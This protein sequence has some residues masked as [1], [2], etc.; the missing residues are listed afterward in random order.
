MVEFKDRLTRFGFDYLKRYFE[1]HGT[2][3]EV[4]EETEKGY[5]E[6]LIED[7]DSIV[8]GF[9]TRIY[10]KRSKKYRKIKKAIEEVIKVIKTIEKTIKFKLIP[11]AESDRNKLLTLLNDYAAMIREA[12]IMIMKNDDRSRK[13]AHGLC[14]RSLRNKYPYLHNKFA[15]EAYKRALAMYR[16]YRELLNKWRKLPE[17]KKKVSPPSP[18]KIKDNNVTELHIDTYKLERMYRFLI[19]VVSKGNGE[20]LRFLIMEYDYARRELMKTKLGN[21][22]ILVDGDVIFLLLTIRGNVEVREHRNKLIVDIKEDSI[23]CLLVNYDKW[24]A[25]LFSIRHDIRKIRTNYR[26]IR[27]SVQEKVRNPRIRNKLL[28]KYGFRE[29]KRIEDR[30]KKITTLLAEIA[31][32]YNADLVRENLRDLKLN[33]RKRSKQLNYRLPTFPYRR[34]ILYIDYKFYERGLSVIEDD[35]KKLLLLAQYVVARIGRNRTNKETFRCKRCGFTFSA[36]YVACL[37]LFSRSNDSIVA[38]R[39]GG[40]TLISRKAGPVVPV[41]VAPDEPPNQM[42][43]LREKPV[44]VSIISKIP[45][46]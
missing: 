31:R 33:G 42:R 22:K 26:R 38:I 5:M 1:S 28:A 6:E 34:F 44:Q 16:S 29:R 41:N 39:S 20:Y 9:A 23:D 13:K 10:G 21:S 40:L 37:N 32:E 43:W 25:L 24:K 11:L 3:V 2:R 35:A 45:K 8:I 7:F 36:Q 17:N 4:V 46:I 19:L 14:Y 30:L 12:L 27:K 15:Q 18:P